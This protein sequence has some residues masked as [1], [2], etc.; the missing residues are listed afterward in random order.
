[1]RF[2][3]TTMFLLLNGIIAFALV[4]YFT[5]WLLSAKTVAVIVPPYNA[6]TINIQYEVEGNMYVSRHLRNEI[7][8]YQKTI[9]VHYYL[10]NPAKSR[11][12]SYLGLFAEPLGWWLVFLMASS[13]LL[14]MPNTVFS[15]GT[16]FQL[17][18]KFPWISM[19]EYFPAPAEKYRRE[20]RKKSP[21]VRKPKRLEGNKGN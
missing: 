7:P 10:F 3:K 8:F 4:I 1:M 6:N 18:K 13:M 16:M 19:D 17:Q 20:E 21:P 2:G 12:I 14:L 9:E 11:I 5:T 15:K